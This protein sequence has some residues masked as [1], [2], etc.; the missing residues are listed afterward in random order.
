MDLNFILPPAL[1]QGSFVF[2]CFLVRWNFYVATAS[3]PTH[4]TFSLNFHHL[5]CI[6][7]NCSV[8]VCVCLCVSLYCPSWSQTSALVSIAGTP[9]VYT[10]HGF[11][12]V[13]GSHCCPSKLLKYL[14]ILCFKVVLSVFVFLIYFNI[15]VMWNADLIV[16]ISTL[17]A[18]FHIRLIVLS[19]NT[20]RFSM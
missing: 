2:F 20:C 6:S 15:S 17:W 8:C 7:P 18:T 11:S 1:S 4:C 13:Y 19:V 5:K 10:T 12:F 14:P 3:F 16:L 9:G